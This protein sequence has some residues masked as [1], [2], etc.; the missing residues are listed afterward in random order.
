MS[1]P[2]NVAL[3]LAGAVTK[4]AFEAGAIEVIASRN[5]G[6]RRIVAASSGALNGTAFAAAVRARREIAAARELVEVWE[7]E[8]DLAG[9]IHPSLR[10]LLGRRGIS[11]Q[12]KLLAL[13]RRHVKPAHIAD[14][15]PIDLR[16]MVAP[17]RGGAGRVDGEPATTYS[18]IV[19]FEG[20]D[21]DD[22]ERLDRVFVA[23][24]ASAAL[25]VL[26]APVDVPDLGLCTDGG[27]VNNTPLLAAFG[28]DRG[29]SLDAILVVAPTP[30][31]IEAPV[32]DYRGLELL[33]HQIDMVYAEWLYQDLRRAVR[34]NEGLSR[35]DALAARR[36][37]TP[38][39]VEEIKAS[40]G[41]EQARYMPIVSIR[42][43]TRL[44]GDIFSGFTDPAVRHTYVEL[45]RARA[46]EVL[47]HMG[48]R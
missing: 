29:A 45:G 30:A 10:A 24:T 37:W 26:F 3:V 34:Q 48:W 27:L 39:Q 1:A 7:R 9:A 13:L 38:P 2:R 4:G 31:L 22:A 46:V 44:P 32:D 6:V 8:A 28:E 17:L 11:D 19:P 20:S 15:A 43:S 12:K 33:A 14:P 42:P 23:A 35:L 36:G 21:F 16:I 41:L 25:P 47:D 18:H 40:L 5:I